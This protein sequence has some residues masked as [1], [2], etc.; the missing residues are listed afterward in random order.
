MRAPAAAYW[1]SGMLLP[2]PRR[3]RR[4]S[5]LAARRELLDGL[6]RGGDAR[7][8]RPGLAW[9]ADQHGGIPSVAAAAFRCKRLIMVGRSPYRNSGSA[10]GNRVRNPQDACAA[11]RSSRLSNRSSDVRP[12][13]PCRRCPACAAPTDRRARARSPPRRRPRRLCP[14]IEHQRP[15][16]DLADRIGDALARDVG[17]RAVHRLE[18]RGNSRSGLMFADGAMPIVPQTAGPRS[19]RMS[20]NRFE[21]TT[22]SKR[23]GRWTKS[24][25]RMSM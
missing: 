6:G 17:R 18:Q 15:R 4:R 14:R 9:N 11:Q 24:A 8:A 3:F 19:D 7:F 22:T 21:P 25:V 5:V 16:P 10:I 13:S 12:S 1:S 20:P 23:S 2:A